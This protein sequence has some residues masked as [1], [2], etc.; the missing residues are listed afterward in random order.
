MKDNNNLISLNCPNCR[1]SISCNSK[2]M[3][4]TCEHCGTSILI[5]D[6]ITKARINSQ[7]KLESNLAMAENALKTQNWNQAC[8][9]YESICKITKS[10]EDMYIYNALS[11]ICGKIE[12]RVEILKNCKMI[13]IAKRKIILDGLKRHIESLRVNE[14]KLAE[15]KY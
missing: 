7:D 9:Y 5:K 13:D 14:I 11:Y 8:K 12:F 4:I 10:N 2:E 1:A 15:N 6:F 3:M